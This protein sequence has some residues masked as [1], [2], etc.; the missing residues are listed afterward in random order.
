MTSMVHYSSVPLSEVL[1]SHGDTE[2]GE[3]YY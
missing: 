1:S 3:F 2:A